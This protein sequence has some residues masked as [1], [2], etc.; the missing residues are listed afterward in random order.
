[1]TTEALYFDTLNSSLSTLLSGRVFPIKLPQNT[2]FPAL[3][4]SVGSAEADGY[5][6]L[7]S[8]PPYTFEFENV[9]YASSY[10][11][12]IQITDAL[13]D[14]CATQ[15]WNISGY[16]DGNY[17]EDLKTYSRTVSITVVSTL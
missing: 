13:R 15:N 9:F 4:Y 6:E 12:I 7:G 8:P 16:S 14:M 2:V 11:Q 1:M 17:D 10:A 5:L 3:L